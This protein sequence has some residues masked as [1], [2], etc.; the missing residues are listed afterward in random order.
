MVRLLIILMLL[1]SI[2]AQATNYY[3][4]TSGSDSANGLT[5]ATAWA[6]LTKVNGSTIMAGDSVLF[7]R[8]D[9]FTGQLVPKSGTTGNSIIYAAYGTGAKPII[10]GFQT[11]GAWSLYSTGIYRATT[12]ATATCNMVTIDGVNTPKGRYPNAGFL[13]YESHSGLTQITDN[14]LAASPSFIGAQVVVRPNRWK[15]EVSTITA[16]SGTT[17][18]FDAIND[19]PANGYGYFFQNSPHVLDALGEWYVSGGYLYMYFGAVSPGTKTVKASTVDILVNSISKSY[20]QLQNIAF[21]G[22]NDRAVKIYN[23][24]SV[25]VKNCDFSACGTLGIEADGS[26]AG[27]ALTVEGCT[28]TAVQSCAVYS[29]SANTTVRGNSVTNVGLWPGMGN[30]NW[31]N[32]SA[33]SINGNSSLAE[34]NNIHNCGYVGLQIRGNGTVAKNNLI[35]VF[36]SVL[37][38][39][40]GIYTSAPTWSGR[41]I[42]G[43]IVLNGS[44]A[45]SGAPTGSTTQTFGIYLDEGATDVTISDNTVYSSDGSMRAGILLHVSEN[46]DITGNTVFNCERQMYISNNQANVAEMTE[47]NITN[48]IFVAREAS[49]TCFSFVSIYNDL[50]FGSA[51]GN[52]YARPIADTQ[53]FSIDTYNTSATAYDLAG[54]QALS[55]YDA[56]STGSPKTIATTDDLFFAYNTTSSA[57]IVGLDGGYIDMKNQAHLVSVSLPAYSSV[58]LLKS[59]NTNPEGTKKPWL[60]QP[61]NRLLIYNGKYFNGE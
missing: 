21:Q 35:D 57:S 45:L 41:V 40:G 14:Q 27:S 39:G 6:T 55:G 32:Y 42:T 15:L 26:P 12:T 2:E 7:R 30:D 43:N 33:L 61:G 8:G 29:Y 38:D 46:V 18:V 50:N 10:S 1:C 56:N 34:Y 16:H 51:S 53:V 9:V 20:Y 17:L 59:E 37:D 3:V 54:W 13:T 60:V 31:G 28:F 48:N 52:V 49:Q 44:T 11:I 5:S 47:V 19:E 22:A 23:P 24:V 58:V 4:S 36:C 25:V